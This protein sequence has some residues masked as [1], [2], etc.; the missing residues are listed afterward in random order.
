MAARKK[1]AKKTAKKAAG[2]STVAKKASKINGLSQAHGK[3]E[4]NQ[5]TTL[6]QIWGDTGMHKYKTLDELE[7]KEQLNDMAK[8]DLQAHAVK[9]GL[10]PIDN[11]GQL[12]KR[13]L[14]EFKKYVS[15]YKVPN[16]NSKSLSLDKEALRILNEGK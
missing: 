13:L 1:T 10:I 7:Y 8:V 9:I 3:V 6:D 2:K 14:V 12:K 5:P 15:G 4:G 11:P 16:A